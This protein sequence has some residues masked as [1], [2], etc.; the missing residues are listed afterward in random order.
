MNRARQHQQTA[1][2]LPLAHAF[3]LPAAPDGALASALADNSG[4]SS[5][6]ANRSDWNLRGWTEFGA[7]SERPM[8]RRRLGLWLALLLLDVKWQL[9]LPVARDGRRAQTSDRATRRQRRIWAANVSA[10]A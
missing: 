9:P 3:D 2:F 10:S 1:L 6:S 5:S 4:T 7:S 8:S